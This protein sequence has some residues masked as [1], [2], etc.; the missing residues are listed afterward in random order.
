MSSAPVSTIGS[1]V[2]F[3]F[4]SAAS[5]SEDKLSLLLYLTY[6]NV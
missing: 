6:L 5:S 2:L 3:F 1:V 4:S